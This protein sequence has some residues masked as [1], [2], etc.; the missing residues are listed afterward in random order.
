MA[1]PPQ[2]LL[3][4]A[5]M[6]KNRKSPTAQIKEA[7]APATDAL[8]NDI[9]PLVSMSAK[10]GTMYN[11]RAEDPN[12]R[13]GIATGAIGGAADGF[14]AGGLGGLFTGGILGGLGGAIA[15]GNAKEQKAEQDKYTYLNQMYG[16]V[17][18]EDYNLQSLLYAEEGGEIISPEGEVFVPIQTEAKKIGNKLVKEKLIFSDGKIADVN[19]TKPHSEQKKD[20]VTDI[21]VEGTY[22]MPVSTK[23]SK[24]D[25]DSL[26]NYSTSNYS[27]NGKNFGVEK[28]TLRNILGDDFE[29]SFAEATDIVTKKYP[30]ADNEDDL[31]PI[32]RVTNN[33][34]IANRSK[35]I[36][37]LMRLNEAKINKEPIEETKLTPSMKAKVG[38]YVQKYVLKPSMF[39]K[40]GGYVNKMEE[41]GNV[42]DPPKKGRRYK[43]LIF[44]DDGKWYII[45]KDEKVK[46]YSNA[47]QIYSIPDNVMFKDVEFNDE[48]G[49][50]RDATW[51]GIDLKTLPMSLADGTKLAQK[52][53]P[54]IV[55]PYDNTIQK[56]NKD[57]AIEPWSREKQK[58]YIKDIRLH[59][60]YESTPVYYNHD[61][62]EVYDQKLNPIRT[63]PALML[64]DEEKPP[65][66]QSVQNAE[67]R[68]RQSEAGI[69]SG[70]NSD[71]KNL[72]GKGVTVSEEQKTNAEKSGVLYNDKGVTYQTKKE[73]I[74]GT[75]DKYR[76]IK[77][78]TTDQTGRPLN[79]PKKLG[80]VDDKGNIINESNPSEK[81]GVTIYGSQEPVYGK[82]PVYFTEQE[83]IPGTNKYRTVKVQIADENGKPMKAKRLNYND[84]TA[85]TT[86]E[87]NTTSS[88]PKEDNYEYVT[89]KEGNTFK[90][91]KGT[92]D[93]WLKDDNPESKAKALASQN[94]IPQ[95]NITAIPNNNAPQKTNNDTLISKDYNK[96]N[97]IITLPSNTP[98]QDKTV[99]S[100]KIEPNQKVNSVV[101]TN[102]TT[103]PN[104]INT[105]GTTPTNITPTANNIP[106]GKRYK[107]KNGETIIIGDDNKYYWENKDGSY[108]EAAPQIVDVFKKEMAIDSV[109]NPSGP[110]NPW[111]IQNSPTNTQKYNPIKP[112]EIRNKVDI[113]PLPVNSIDPIKSTGYIEPILGSYRTTSSITNMLKEFGRN[114][115]T[116]NKQRPSITGRPYLIQKAN[117][118]L[119]PTDLY[120]DVVNTL[121]SSNTSVNTDSTQTNGENKY[122]PKGGYYIPGE[123]KNRY[124]KD[125]EGNWYV[126][127]NDGKTWVPAN[128]L[129]NS[130][131][132]INKLNNESK[133]WNVAQNKYNNNGSNAKQYH[134]RSLV[135]QKINNTVSSANTQSKQYI[136]DP[137]AD[138][139][140]VVKFGYDMDANNF[141]NEGILTNF[142]DYTD[143]EIE[144]IYLAHTGT[145]RY[146][147]S[148]ST[149]DLYRKK[150][151]EEKIR[152]SKNIQIKKK[153]G[154]IRKMAIGGFNGGP[155]VPIIPE[156]WRDIWAI[157]ETG[158]A[159]YY[160]MPTM[161]ENPFYNMSPID[162][163]SNGLPVT[164]EN[165][166][167]FNG[168]TAPLPNGATPSSRTNTTG[169]TNINP[170]ETEMLDEIKSMISE[171]SGDAIRDAE[172]SKKGYKDL[173]RRVGMRD[174]MQ[175]GN[176][177]IGIGLQDR[178]ERR[179]FKR[180]L[181]IDQKYRGLSPQQINQESEA[182]TGAGVEMVKNMLNAG[183]DRVTARLAPILVEKLIGQQGRNRK[184]YV[185]QNTQLERSKY[186]ER[187]AIQQFNLDE[188][189]RASRVEQD[190]TNKAIAGTSNVFNKYISSRSD[191]DISKFKVDEGINR[192]LTDKLYK[193]ENRQLQADIIGKDYEMQMSEINKKIADIEFE[194]NR[195]DI[196]AAQKASLKSY[197]D[198]YKKMAEDIEKRRINNQIKGK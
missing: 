71:N 111:T 173:S 104:V 76:N 4:A 130:A 117:Q 189:Q 65:K 18:G 193:L 145:R 197:Q 122:I 12:M 36:A 77:Y 20:D 166:Y 163:I 161:A 63:G 132:V 57:G 101:P 29:G 72:I 131:E 62:N 100:E 125:S 123:N 55:H 149:I 1:I 87:K 196:D 110:I 41:G 5:R 38:G 112:Q 14:Q 28:I 160:Q 127:K 70:V 115:N 195:T 114:T 116:E 159:P 11:L 172:E 167:G 180:P 90:R 67:W 69:T 134:K 80:E 137:N 49:E 183:G 22:V 81:K 13:T 146:H 179:S 99:I 148:P 187:G 27:E 78:Q 15:T 175:L 68:K 192:D 10:A 74:P 194:L 7:L 184:A 45:D 157:D 85:A 53:G 93:S 64:K 153:G 34:N 40:K 141:F 121:P 25:L 138:L 182:A 24:K 50:V 17:V 136:G 191:A 73:L 170:G 56:I 94:Q 59:K 139:E 6:L 154:Y 61:K 95:T 124:D 89:S 176:S 181:Y 82:G 21:T 26:I 43:N 152:R 86:P 97:P 96:T 51:D 60:Y 58:E 23:L 91:K 113:K 188:E 9:S 186:D 48:T 8:K 155:T 168:Q 88:T 52:R 135:K 178:S 35:I 106:S 128:S 2:L 198:S 164:D 47:D 83:Q 158:Q 108:K 75:T 30:V 98:N 119:T 44:S 79:E 39:L 151:K 171:R 16:S 102:P 140:S 174:L 177:L 143:K 103:I 147:G 84:E 144:D 46:K 42:G 118:N 126:Q 185:D 162:K 105:Q 32:A 142:K 33:E 92:Q 165:P 31:D 107:S 109:K 129:P 66:R 3:A 190:N 54:Y 37:H 150:L 133:Q 169:K 19:A 120:S 156:K